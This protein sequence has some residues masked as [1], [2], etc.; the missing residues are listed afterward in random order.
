MTETVDDQ[1]PADVDRLLHQKTAVAKL[2]AAA[3]SV[4]RRP[5]VAKDLWRFNEDALKASDRL[6]RFLSGLVKNLPR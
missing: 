2:G 3:G 6:A 4:W 1:L 5:S